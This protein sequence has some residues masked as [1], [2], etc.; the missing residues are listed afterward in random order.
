MT[1]FEPSPSRA[2]EPQKM[3]IFSQYL[4]NIRYEVLHQVGHVAEVRNVLGIEYEAEVRH[5]FWV[6]IGQAL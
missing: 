4:E 1:I 6:E 2:F 3:E 5:V